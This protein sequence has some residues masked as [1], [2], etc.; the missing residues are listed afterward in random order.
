MMNQ[1]AVLLSSPVFGGVVV[2]GEVVVFVPDSDDVV[3]DLFAT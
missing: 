2:F 3:F 1:S